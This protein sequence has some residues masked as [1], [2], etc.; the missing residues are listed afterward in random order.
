M[1]L[2][3]HLSSS[4]P[5][6]AKIILTIAEKSRD[7]HAAFLTTMGVSDTQN[8]YGETQE[9]LEKFADQH[10]I[11]AMRDTGVVGSIASEEQSEI[12]QTGTPGLAVA[13]DPL[14][15]SSCIRTNLTVGTIAGIFQGSLLG[16]PNIIGAVYVLYGPLTTLVYSTGRGVHEF[17][18]QDNEFVLRKADLQIPEGKINAPGGLKTQVVP[19]HR[20]VMDTLDSQGY[21][22]R[23]TGSFVAD[24]NNILTYGGMYSYPALKEKPQGKLR[25][26]FEGYPM[27]YLAEHAGGKA[28]DGKQ[29]ILDITA[30]VVNQRTP[31]YIGSKILVESIHVGGSA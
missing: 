16:E 25:L 13:F 29:P 10:L 2:A 18:F 27:A 26:L 17:V 30:Q 23:Y 20:L 14:D 6:V 28:T 11:Q 15:G 5:T 22:I 31:L 7:I 4:D 8:V 21:K 24:F 3:E 12:I 9:E 1:N 19:E